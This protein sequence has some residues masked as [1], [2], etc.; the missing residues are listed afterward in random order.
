MNH[1]I[2]TE[3][4]P[5]AYHLVGSAATG[6]NRP[7]VCS[8][9]LVTSGVIQSRAGTAIPVVNRSSRPVKGLTVSVNFQAPSGKAQL[10]SGRPLIV[11][12]QNEHREYQFDLDVADAIIL[13]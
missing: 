6:V 4:D 8:E 3:F 10:A 12:Q 1:F 2:P 13:R 11:R 5:G 9:P 7:V